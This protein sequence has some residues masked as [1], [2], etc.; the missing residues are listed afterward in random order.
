MLR[1]TRL[2]APGTLNHV[3]KG[4][5]QITDNQKVL[6]RLIEKYLCPVFVARVIAEVA[7]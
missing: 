2:D 3:M 4:N 5:D 1:Q 7:S 6:F